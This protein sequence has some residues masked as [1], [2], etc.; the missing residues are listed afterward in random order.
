MGHIRR[1]ARRRAPAPEVAEVADLCRVAL[2]SGFTVLRAVALVAAHL[3]TPTAAA[4]GR[5]V[6]D[7]DDDRGD[8]GGSGVSGSPVDALAALPDEL[9]EASRELCAALVAAARDGA[10]VLPALER[11]AFELRLQRRLDAEVHAR[12]T[13][14]L[15]LFPLVGCVLPAF[16]LLAVVPLVLGA[17]AALPGATP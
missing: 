13:S 2:A 7:H 9:G 17:L 16:V 12:R 11:V 10:P 3:D 14:V 8:P 15:L 5:A 1:P 6:T 4:F